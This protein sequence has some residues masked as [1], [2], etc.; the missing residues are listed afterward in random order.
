MVW[1]VDC[2]VENALNC[3]RESKK[4]CAKRIFSKQ[5]SCSSIA[6]IADNRVDNLLHIMQ[7]LDVLGLSLYFDHKGH[8]YNFS[9]PTWHSTCMTRSKRQPLF[10]G[11]GYNLTKIEDACNELAIVNEEQIAKGKYEKHAI[12]YARY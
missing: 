5:P 9:G 11:Y 3:T 10:C 12:T 8:D 1:C 4:Y 7:L 2:E 6:A